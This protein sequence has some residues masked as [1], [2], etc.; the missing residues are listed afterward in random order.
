MEM[1]KSGMTFA[2]SNAFTAKVCSGS[3]LTVWCTDIE[4]R[5]RRGRDAGG[6]KEN[7]RENI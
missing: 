6:E 3:S 7:D 5:G 1:K 4:S 2:E